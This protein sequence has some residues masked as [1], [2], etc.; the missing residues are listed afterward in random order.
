MAEA[1]LRLEDIGADEADA[2]SALFA[3]ATDTALDALMPTPVSH[4][5]VTYW[6]YCTSVLYAD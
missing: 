2:L 6:L 4:L 5:L 3:S 1:L